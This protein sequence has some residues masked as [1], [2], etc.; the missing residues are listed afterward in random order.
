[1]VVSDGY[2]EVFNNLATFHSYVSLA[3]KEQQY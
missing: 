1:M 2:A 3:V